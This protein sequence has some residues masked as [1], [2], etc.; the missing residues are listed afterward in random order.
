LWRTARGRVYRSDTYSAWLD[1]V[2]IIIKQQMRGQL[3]ITGRF[4]LKVRARRPDKRRRDI[5]NILKALA[6]GLV[7]CGVI[8]DDHLCE[9]IDIRWVDAGDPCEVEITSIVSD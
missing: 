8:E 2:Y 7:K 5:D 3:A 1:A 9:G 4:E 6:D